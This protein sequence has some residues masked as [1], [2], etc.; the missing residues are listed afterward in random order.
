MITADGKCDSKCSTC[1][2]VQQAYCKLVQFRTE[3]D[4]KLSER[5]DRLEASIDAL[6]KRLNS[7]LIIAQRG[8]GAEKV[9]EESTI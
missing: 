3:E 9:A 4:S 5:L 8:D 7:E 6:D 2:I 1:N